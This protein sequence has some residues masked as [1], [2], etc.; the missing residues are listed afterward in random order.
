MVTKNIALLTGN[1][2]LTTWQSKPKSSRQSFEPQNRCSRASRFES[3]IRQTC[4]GRNQRTN[5]ASPEQPRRSAQGSRNGLRQRR[6]RN[7]V[8]LGHEQFPIHEQHLQRV[9][10][11]TASTRPF[12]S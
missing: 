11:L 2:S 12:N 4:G 1:Q 6:P 3:K 8:P 9:L 10:Q 5:E 7:G